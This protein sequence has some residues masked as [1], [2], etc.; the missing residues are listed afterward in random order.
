M[1]VTDLV[2][3]VT[4]TDLVRGV[5]TRGPH[6]DTKLLLNLVNFEWLQKF[7]AAQERVNFELAAAH[8]VRESGGGF[9][10]WCGGVSRGCLRRSLAAVLRLEF[11]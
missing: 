11:Q 10:G 5:P 4:V 9:P 2:R 6:H 8:H 7:C 1:A 3:G